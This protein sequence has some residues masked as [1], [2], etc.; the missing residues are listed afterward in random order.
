MLF[1][2]WNFN[3]HYLSASDGVFIE[4]ALEDD[5]NVSKPVFPTIPTVYATIW[6]H[7][8]GAHGADGAAVRAAEI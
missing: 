6:N 2:L 1:N 7:A 4:E 5:T 3:P 8:T